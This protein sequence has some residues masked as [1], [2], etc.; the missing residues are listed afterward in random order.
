[1][2]LFSFLATPIVAASCGGCLV[3]VVRRKTKDEK[4]MKLRCYIITID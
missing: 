1:L 3:V 2:R 4:L